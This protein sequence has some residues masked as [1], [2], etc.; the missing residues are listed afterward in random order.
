MDSRSCNYTAT[1][2]ATGPAPNTDFAEI[3]ELAFS[4]AIRW[5]KDMENWVGS[6]VFGY[7]YP[8]RQRCPVWQEK[9]KAKPKGAANI[10]VFVSV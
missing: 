6:A 7:V 10:K 8:I 4:K 1:Q 9:N 3:L 2:V 5:T